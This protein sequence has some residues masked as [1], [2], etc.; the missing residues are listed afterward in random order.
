MKTL[1]TVFCLAAFLSFSAVHAQVPRLI[2]VQGILSGDPTNP[3][4]GPVSMSLRI[5]TDATGGTMLFQEVQNT[6]VQQG[7]FNI[8][9]GATLQGGLPVTL[10][11]NRRYWLGVAIN[12]GLE[13]TPRLPLAS[14]PYALSIADSTISP[15]KISRKGAASANQAMVTT[16]NGV[17]WKGV[18][19]KL[20]GEGPVI[21]EP[22]NGI[23]DL[24]VRLATNS[25]RSE[26]IAPGTLTYDRF[27]TTGNPKD[28]DVLTYL[29]N[30]P[31]GR[32]VWR[33]PEAVPFVL[34]YSGTGDIAGTPAFAVTNINNGTAG[35]FAVNFLANNSPA[36]IA[37][38][39]GLGSA[40]AAT[41]TGTGTGAVFTVSN[42]GSSA[43]AARAETNGS[44]YAFEGNATSATLKSNGIIGRSATSADSVAG[45]SGVIS[46]TTPGASASGIA[47]SVTSTT[48]RGFGV[49]GR[50]AGRGVGV[51]GS[52]TA[53]VGIK[54]ISRD[55]VGIWGGHTATTGTYSGIYGS[56]ASVSDTA[57]GIIGE[58]T[59]KTG[60][61]NSVGVKGIHNDTLA[62]GSGVWGLH[63]GRGTGVFGSA[64]MGVGVRGISRDSM[65]VA[66]Y[67]TGG[68]GRFAGVYG[69]T[70][71]S[72][73]DATG[74]QGSVNNTVPGVG[75]AGVRGTNNGSF[76]NGYG[77]YGAHAGKGTGV[78]GT[79]T[80]GTGVAGVVQGEE[81]TVGVLG[82]SAST[83]GTGVSGQSTATSGR[84][85]GVWASSASDSGT[86]V[87]GVNNR[88]GGGAYAGYFQGKINVT[89]DITKTYS[90]TGANGERRAMPI[91]YATIA[92]NGVITAGTPNIS[93]AWDGALGAYLITIQNE[94]FTETAFTCLV[95]PSS[96]TPLIPVTSQ[97][98]NSRLMVKLFTLSNTTAQSAFQVVIFKP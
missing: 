26:Y 28:G 64:M 91:G 61:I 51:M 25:I 31:A 72:A 93:C 54:G 6:E 22:F 74:V 94:L 67:H 88:T 71:A 2:S 95:T 17:E 36:L 44:G 56:S 86:A 82:S 53:G 77:V 4:N 45:V 85:Y 35:R 37:E 39:N 49:W 3:I 55:S 38:N 65:G 14:A 68:S 12:D 92:S 97:G 19:T 59:S 73:Q 40:L 11:F 47:G 48:A 34:P 69:E 10:D 33:A 75:S 43:A 1:L 21:V 90:T 7:L 84:N 32:L 57:A 66:G 20:S 63:N 78:F 60:G 70:V 27:N 98:A 46:A 79:A 18:V 23:G 80:E 15:V 41:T 81:A 16:A 8:Y 42:V 9:L 96:G 30:P 52:T 62:N 83:I 29:G 87:Y 76:S 24:T 13:L 50:H 5:Y 58:M 89:G